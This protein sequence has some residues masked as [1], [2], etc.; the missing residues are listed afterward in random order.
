MATNVVAITELVIND[1]FD[2]YKDYETKYTR[3]H[4]EN[5]LVY[6]TV[7]IKRVETVNKKLGQ[8]QKRFQADH[9]YSA[10]RFA[11]VYRWHEVSKQ[12]NAHTI[13]IMPLSH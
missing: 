12:N 1:C 10:V 4:D 5:H 3:L 9:V 11:C 13:S 2:T 6:S 7:F 8:D